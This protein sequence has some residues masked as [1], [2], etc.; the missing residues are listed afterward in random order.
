MAP[1]DAH[2][3]QRERPFSDI[4]DLT[5]V[6]MRADCG[7]DRLVRMAKHKTYTDKRRP[8]SARQTASGGWV[9]ARNSKSGQFTMGRDA[10][11][12]ISEVEG[13]VLTRGLKED[14]RRLGR[15]SPEKRR[16][17]LAEK[18]GKKRHR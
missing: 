9:V 4:C 11:G 14:L 10:F 5:T 2:R 8:G 3:L 6:S 17:V 7:R 1:R 13:I 15:A 16:A 12:K 18:Y